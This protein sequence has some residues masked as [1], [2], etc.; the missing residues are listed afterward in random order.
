ML[1]K[2]VLPDIP[3]HHIRYQTVKKISRALDNYPPRDP[4]A[5]AKNLAKAT[6]AISERD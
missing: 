5:A 4:K 1:I 3:P 6:L 2:T